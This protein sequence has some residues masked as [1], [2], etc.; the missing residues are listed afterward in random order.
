MLLMSSGIIRRAS[1]LR[2]PIDWLF[3]LYHH[4]R[5]P[6]ALGLAPSVPFLSRTTVEASPVLVDLL[7]LWLSQ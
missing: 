3:R 5:I 4:V 1:G 6:A 2:I 7:A